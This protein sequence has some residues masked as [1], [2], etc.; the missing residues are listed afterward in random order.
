M[1]YKIQELKTLGCSERRTAREL[2]ID[3]AT[4]KKYRAMDEEAYLRCK[5]SARE[6]GRITDEYREKTID[7]LN[8]Y[9]EIPAIVG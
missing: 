1:Y 9:P 3:R 6:R 7:R 2:G 4:V 8:E 5:E